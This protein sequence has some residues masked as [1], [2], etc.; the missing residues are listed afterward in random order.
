[1]GRCILCGHIHPLDV[2]GVCDNCYCC[3]DYL[4]QSSHRAHVRWILDGRP[5]DT[6]DPWAT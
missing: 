1:M 3:M 6:S 5:V 2:A 4:E